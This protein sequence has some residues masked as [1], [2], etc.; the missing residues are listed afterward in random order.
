MKGE[1]KRGGKRTKEKKGG[2][3][4]KLPDMGFKPVYG[5][6]ICVTLA[7]KLLRSKFV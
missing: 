4:K 1:K 5:H 6:L 2:E 3:K 7:T